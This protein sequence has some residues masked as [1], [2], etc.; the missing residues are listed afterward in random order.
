VAVALAFARAVASAALLLGIARGEEP[1]PALPPRPREDANWVDA[2][3]RFLESQLSGLTERLD[4][5]FGDE[6]TYDLE[7][8]ESF[9]RLRN[10]LRIAQDR[11]FAFRLRALASLKLP[12]LDR[13]LSN[14]RVVASGESQAAP[15]PALSE[16]PANPA[17][18][19]GL[20]AEQ[21]N[22]EL[23][24]DLLHA[25]PTVVDIGSGVRLRLPPEPFV[26]SRLRRRLEPGL[27]VTGRFTQAVFWTNREGF[28]ESTDLDL[29]RPLGA[30]TLLRSGGEAALSE[31]SPGLAWAGELG[32]AREIESLR[33]AAYLAGAA[34]GHTRPVARVDLYRTFLRLRRDFWRRWLFVELEPEVGWPWT[35]ERGRHRVLAITVRLEVQVVGRGEDLPTPAAP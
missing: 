20:K 4:S 21:A 3:H 33:T 25:P 22:L 35:P 29:E 7:P 6:R 1:A 24:L 2:S 15:A 27:G 31:V 14:A 34:N 12:A 26:R 16:D 28:G 18:S 30:H 10:E 11:L 5:F 32:V 8:A 19:P 17:Y 9:I 23:R 13:W